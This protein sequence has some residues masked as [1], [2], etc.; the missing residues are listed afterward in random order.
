MQTQTSNT[1]SW[2]ISRSTNALQATLV[3]QE[4]ER[5][6]AEATAT[7]SDAQ[8]RLTEAWTNAQE[9][10]FN[11]ALRIVRNDADA[12]DCAMD[13]WMRLAPQADKI[14]DM[15]KALSQACRHSA[16]D[17]LRA[18]R[19]R[20]LAPVASI[21]ETAALGARHNRKALYN[22][23]AAE[24]TLVDWVREQCSPKELGI[25]NSYLEH[26][27]LHELV[28]K[29]QGCDVK[30]VS[31]TLERIGRRLGV[32]RMQWRTLYL[33][34]KGTIPGVHHERV[35]SLLSLLACAC[36]YGSPVDLR[37]KYPVKDRYYP[38]ARRRSVP[39]WEYVPAGYV[40]TEYSVGVAHASVEYWRQVSDTVVC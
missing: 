23:K 31:R 40:S 12:G 7:L 17:V 22:T 10:L 28:A 20:P 16:L 24:S 29:G 39:R 32:S 4:A 30:T 35:T 1:P 34:T 18:R 36:E 8:T 26:H 9:R 6:H 25:I 11:Q 37:G 3:L 13:A 33:S 14:R 2:E 19:T 5:D 21:E 15:H 27:G 38:P